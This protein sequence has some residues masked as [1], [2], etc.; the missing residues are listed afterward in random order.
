MAHGFSLQDQYGFPYSLDQSRGQAVALYFGFTHCLDIC[1]ETLARLGKART[2]AGLSSRD[3]RIAMIT[4]DPAR[5]SGKALQGFLRKVGVEATGLRGTPAQLQAVYRA[6]GI[7]VKPEKN[8]IVHTD[9]IFLID[10]AG[11]LRELLDAQTALN[12]VAA[13]MRAIVD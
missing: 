9:T 3:L 8:D 7:A 1:P 6:Y 10:G 11:R 4:V 13:D 5:D 2:K 12:D